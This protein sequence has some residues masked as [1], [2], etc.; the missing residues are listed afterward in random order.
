MF[1]FHFHKWKYVREY[2]KD[3]FLDVVILRYF[4]HYRI[5]SKCGKSQ[6]AEYPFDW[7]TIGEVETNI[8]KS[9]ILDKDTYYIL[10]Y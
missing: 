3:T 4:E 9:K 1:K 2:F 7:C 5:C 8:L 6:Q 10:E